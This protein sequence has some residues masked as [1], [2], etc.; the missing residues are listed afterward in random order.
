M[1]M[2]EKRSRGSSS[3]GETGGGSTSLST[4]GGKKAWAAPQGT[5]A[6]CM[7][8][9]IAYKGVKGK[10]QAWQP[11]PYIP[12]RHIQYLRDGVKVFFIHKVFH[13]VGKTT[14]LFKSTD[15]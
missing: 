5:V 13:I 1:C 14:P 2:Y 6:I 12:P 4:S 3:R 7:H 11:L 10:R 9:R 8:V 15:S